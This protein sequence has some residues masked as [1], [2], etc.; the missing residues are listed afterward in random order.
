MTALDKY[1]KGL[2]AIVLTVIVGNA[3][4]EFIIDEI[5]CAASRELQEGHC[6]L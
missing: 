3:I 5:V 1:T 2:L 6:E 4:Y